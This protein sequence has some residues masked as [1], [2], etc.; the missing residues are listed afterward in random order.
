MD[1]GA[2]RP[3]MPRNDAQKQAE[4]AEWALPHMDAI[5]STS[6]YLT[7]NPDEAEELLQET[8]LRA[9]RFWHQFTP[10][11]NCRAWLLTIL[12]NAYRS[13]FRDRF[14]QQATADLSEVDALADLTDLPGAVD[15]PEELVLSQM[16]DGEVH[17]ALQQL[18]A[19]YLEAVLLVDLQELSYEEAA[20][21]VDVPIGTIRSR[22]SRGRRLLHDSL[23][24][25][26]IER[27]Y[28]RR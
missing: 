13:R 11:T 2:R 3:P 5:H 17:E 19:E 24:Q 26:A 4:F 9:F 15:P 25:Y 20:R 12:H 23:K 10:G 18:P 1:G 27:G 16:L 7:R 6:R 8:Y 22:L 21:A 28:V 14:R